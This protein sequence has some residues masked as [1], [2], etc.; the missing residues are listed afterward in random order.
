MNPAPLIS[1]II[2]TRNA[3][4]V[5]GN[6]LG[7]LVQQSFRDFEVWV[8]DSGSVD[9]TLREVHARGNGLGSSLKVHQGN[10]RGTYD[11]MN[12]GVSLSRGRWL[13]FLGADDRLHDPDVFRDLVPHLEDG[14]LHF[15]YGD[16]RMRNGGGRYGGIWSLERML[17]EANICH[18]AIFYRRELFQRLGGFNLRYPIWADWEFNIRCFRHPDLGRLWVDRLVAEYNDKAGL[19]KEKDPMLSRELPVTLLGDERRRSCRF[20]VM[21]RNACD[22]LARWLRF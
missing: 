11:G 8:V 10:D 12:I 14:G 1:V 13:Y 9:D 6:C 16:V 18:Q 5:I 2:P 7:S 15:L 19:S 4:S 22:A 3:G 21:L 17:L 20:C